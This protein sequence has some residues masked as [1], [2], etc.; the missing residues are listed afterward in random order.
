MEMAFSRSI[1]SIQPKT[2]GSTGFVP[3]IHRLTVAGAVDF[4]SSL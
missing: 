1:V 4:P 2:A 3:W